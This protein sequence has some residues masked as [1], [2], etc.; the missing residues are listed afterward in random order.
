M[1]E[2]RG[3]SGER[4]G[5]SVQI[6]VPPEAFAMRHMRDRVTAFAVANGLGRSEIGDFVTAIGE[7]LANAVEHSRAEIV[8]ITCRLDGDALIATVIDRGV[9]FADSPHVALPAETSERGRGFPIMRRCT[10]IFA[11]TSTPGSGTSVV[12][13]L[14]LPGVPASR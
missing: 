12:L 14:F 2:D 10:D 13:G 6:R 8:D 11:L 1:S 4:S 3:R 9:G 5:V 7:A